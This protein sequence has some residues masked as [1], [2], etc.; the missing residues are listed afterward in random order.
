MTW[1]GLIQ[2]DRWPCGHAKTPENTQ[3]GYRQLARC[4]ECHRQRGRDYW[5]RKR[6][7]AIARGE[8]ILPRGR[9]AGSSNVD[10]ADGPLEDEPTLTAEQLAELGRAELKRLGVTGIVGN[11]FERARLRWERAGRRV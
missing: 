6:N 4:K 10:E 2:S 11:E 9:P 8:T 7:E 3:T 5:E 1:D